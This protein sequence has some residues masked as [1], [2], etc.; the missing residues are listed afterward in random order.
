[1]KRVTYILGH[2]NPDADSICA[3][4][5]YADFKNRT[6]DQYEFVPARCG[7]SNARIDTILNRFDVHLPLFIGDLTPR[8]K[9]IMVR[10]VISVNKEATCSEALE[11]IDQY[12]VRAL[13]VL[14]DSSQVE[15]LLSV[16]HLGEFFIPKPASPRS[17]R[18]VHTNI[19]S[20]IR[21]LKADVL[22]I[23]REF[24]V[25]D[26]FVRIGAMD[27]QSFGRFAQEEPQL[28][29]ETIVI[30]GDR[31]DIQQKCIRLGIR[32]LVISGNLSIPEEIVKAAKEQGVSLI[33]SP[34]D[35]ATTSWIIRAATT[36]TR[37]LS[38]KYHCFSAEEKLSEVRRRI[39][40]LNTPAFLVTSED[41][42]L[43]GL[44]TKTDILKPARTRIILVDHNEISQAVNGADQV[45]IAEILDHHRLNNP[46]SNHPVLF[47][48][49][50][51]GSTCSI[52]SDLYRREGIIPTR[53]IAGLLMSGIISDTLNLTSPTTTDKDRRI[54]EWLEPKAGI[55]AKELSDLIF[56]SGSVILSATPAEVI[57]TDFKIYEENQYRFS[58]SQV[59]E[60]GFRNFWQQ[61]ESLEQALEELTHAEAL[62][63]AALLV[64]DINTH[65]SL[66]VIRGNKSF[67]EMISYP[68]IEPGSIFDLPGIVSRKK[69]LIPYL[70]SLLSPERVS[71][72]H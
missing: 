10:D 7:N 50:P 15:G 54:I 71:E 64:T 51:V 20:I 5:T 19:H 62:D 53:E 45:E 28:V 39:T 38:K 29:P 11:L 23:E 60:L 24:D 63:F 36:V 48:N 8:V 69:Q 2:K 41:N 42:K 44:F 3:A 18:H 59:E 40:S 9:D 67:I 43:V 35:T 12:D 68:A 14:N 34:Y 37:V 55:R 33:R 31:L 66:L 57:R 56:N 13:P 16:F 61:S 72:N 4:I 58:V 25:Q 49:E 22:H 21:A 27:V 6:C 46:P 52:I 1:M 26:F 30:V 32:L 65:N 17:M 47:I 70:T